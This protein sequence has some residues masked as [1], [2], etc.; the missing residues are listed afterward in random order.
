LGAI[1]RLACGDVGDAI[2]DDDGSA[3]ANYLLPTGV[4]TLDPLLCEIQSLV[5]QE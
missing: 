4:N 5:P 2:V 1:A 3:L